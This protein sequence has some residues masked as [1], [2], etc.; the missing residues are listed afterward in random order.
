MWCIANHDRQTQ[1]EGALAPKRIN[2]EGTKMNLDEKV[3]ALKEHQKKLKAYHHAVN[4]LS[5]DAST[6]MPPGAAESMSATMGVLSGEI[7]GLT[8]N[9]AFKALLA[10]LYDKREKLDFQTRRE[11]EELYEEQ[12]KMEKVPKE[13]IIAMEEAQAKA[14]HYWEVAK[15]NNDF[16]AF[17]PHLE[18]LIEMKKRYAGCINPDGNVYDTL[19]NEY[20]KGMTQAQMNPFFD[21]LREKLVPLIKAVG[22]AKQPDTSFLAG[23]FDIEAQKELSEY[24]MDVMGIDKERCILRETE[25]P[26][27]MEFSKNDVRITT[28]Y[29]EY[30][31]TSNLYSVI[32]ESGHGMYELSVDDALQFSVLGAGATTAIHESQS[33]LWENYIGRSQSFCQLIFPKVQA[34]FPEQMR[35]VSAEDFY[36]AVNAARPSLIRIDADELTYALHIM[37]RYEIEKQL[38]DGTLSVG[39]L[40]AA[41]NRLYK[42]YLGID[43]PDDTRGVLQDFHWAGGVFGYFPS[44]ALGTAYSAQIYHVL[45]S[46]VD[47]DACC[48]DGNFEPVRKWLI[49]RIYRHGKLYTA[50]ELIQMT[51]GSEF[52]P[53]Y[54]IDYLEKKFKALY[55]L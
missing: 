33:R 16:A 42:A 29:L 5:Y 10:D 6:A 14:T 54:Y 53:A 34:L 20:E 49:E 45:R 46:E 25:H 26:F 31:L 9:P 39:E 18:K 40:P 21:A 17:A 3:K 30:D 47:V 52:D 38:F 22:E 4:L 27:T 11:V 55:D 2:M 13:E 12:S 50:E 36:R 32:H 7:Y 8:V 23:P 43:V 1:A 44:Y 37:V 15:K 28:K 48:K 51:C 24:V 19:L 35:D 41:W